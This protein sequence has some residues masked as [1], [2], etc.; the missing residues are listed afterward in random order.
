M[1]LKVIGSGSSGN[2]YLMDDGINVLII[3]AG[4]R[5]KE[6]KKALGFDLSRVVGCIVTHAHADHGGFAQQYMDAGI[7]VYADIGTI[8]ELGLK[9]HRA[10]ALDPMTLTSINGFTEI[11]KFKVATFD[12]EHDADGPVGYLIEN[13]YM[14]TAL[15]VTDTHYIKYRFD[16]LDHLLIEANF[17]DEILDANVEKRSIHPKLADRIRSSHM[18]IGFVEEFI[19]LNELKPQNTVLI[20]LSDSNSHAAEFKQRVE[21]LVDGNVYIAEPGLT[22]NLDKYPF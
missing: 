3:E 12:V 8:L 11:S 17:S 6:V 13:Q 22:V 4:V 21:Y 9:G 5:F 15:F 2:C 7:N 20:H 1:V 19:E 10:I 16:H 14:G 18:S